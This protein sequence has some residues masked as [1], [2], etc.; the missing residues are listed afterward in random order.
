MKKSILK[1]SPMGLN[2]LQRVLKWSQWSSKG[3]EMVSMVFKGSLVKM[4]F[5]I[6]DENK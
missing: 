5:F 1:G 3:L 6:P 4:I 2:G